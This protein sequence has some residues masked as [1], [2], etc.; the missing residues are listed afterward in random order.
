MMR[1]LGIKV[2]LF[3]ETPNPTSWPRRRLPTTGL[4]ESVGSSL[5]VITFYRRPS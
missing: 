2:S 4:H 1:V 3:D 5:I